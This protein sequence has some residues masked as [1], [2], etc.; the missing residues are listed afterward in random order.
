MPFCFSDA[1][2][3]YGRMKEKRQ[4]II[5]EKLMLASLTSLKEKSRFQI[6]Y[7]LLA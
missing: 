6:V 5:Y 1:I 7:F 2:R 3:V 4:K